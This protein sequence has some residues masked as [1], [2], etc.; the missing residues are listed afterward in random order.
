MVKVG[1]MESLKTEYEKGHTFSEFLKETRESEHPWQDFHHRARVPEEVLSRFRGLTGRWH[2]LVLCEP[3]CGDGANTLPYLAR[4]V[5]AI[6]AL[7]MRVLPRDENPK[8]M[9]ARLTNGNRS[10]PVVM[11]LDEDFREVGWW[12]P[13]P[14]PLQE[15]FLREIRP[16]PKEDRYPRVRAWY[17]RDRGRTAL[18]EILAGMPTPVQE[19]E[20]P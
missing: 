4:V 20:I 8:L 15:F 11:I 5:E 2:F 10:I 18:D 16:L 3:W 9:D 12:G 14:T 13:R 1:S 19:P 17:A 6:P 7:E